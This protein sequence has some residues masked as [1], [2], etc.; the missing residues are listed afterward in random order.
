MNQ[1]DFTN[2][3]FPLK[4][5]CNGHLCEYLDQTEISWLLTQ[6]SYLILWLIF[7]HMSFIIQYDVFLCLY[8]LHLHF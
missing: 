4:C 8:T 5:I 7:E 2:V 1:E 3:I 6:L